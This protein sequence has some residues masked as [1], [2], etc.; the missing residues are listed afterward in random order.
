MV[1]WLDHTVRY[2]PPEDISIRNDEGL[3]EKKHFGASIAH[4][5]SAEFRGLPK[6][7]RE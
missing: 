6:Y 4:A 7:E 2:L 1:T 3:K 5:Y